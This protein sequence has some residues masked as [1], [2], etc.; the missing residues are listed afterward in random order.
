MNRQFFAVC[1]K[2]TES[3]GSLVLCYAAEEG[4]GKVW[5]TN[6]SLNLRGLSMSGP[7]WDE[8]KTAWERMKKKKG[9]D[10]ID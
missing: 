4:G 10:V 9:E 8:L 3:D 7:T 1:G 6:A 2:R 5:S